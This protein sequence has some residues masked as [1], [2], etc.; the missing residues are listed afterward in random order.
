MKTSRG[1][2]F[3]ACCIARESAAITS[4]QQTLKGRKAL[5]GKKGQLLIGGFWHGEAGSGLTTSRTS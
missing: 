2:S 4:I 1:D 3:R 5:R